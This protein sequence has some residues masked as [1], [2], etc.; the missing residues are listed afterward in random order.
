M[1]EC[2]MK[3]KSYNSDKSFPINRFINTRHA[4]ESKPSAKL[5]CGNTFFH[6][7]F[8][9]GL[10]FFVVFYSDYRQTN[11]RGINK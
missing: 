2:R 5:N 6:Q 9:H 7:I 1:I 11:D 8:C 3:I 10:R 4:F